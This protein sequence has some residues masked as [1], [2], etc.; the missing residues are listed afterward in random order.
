ME[1]YIGFHV[2]LRSSYNRFIKDLAKQCKQLV[3]YHLDSVTSPY[4]Q[5]CYENDFVGGLGSTSI[6][7]NQ[8]QVSPFCLELSD[9]R[10]TCIDDQENVPPE[11]SGQKITPDYRR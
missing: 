1:G 10:A 11:K 9:G 6:R 7:F 2:A 4:S 3:R 8:A 5:V